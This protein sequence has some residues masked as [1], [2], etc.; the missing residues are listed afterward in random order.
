MIWRLPAT[1][2]A[3]SAPISPATAV[4]TSTDTAMSRG[5]SLTARP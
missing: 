4:A 5:D 3:S 2:I 1:G